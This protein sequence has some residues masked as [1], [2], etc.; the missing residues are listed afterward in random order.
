VAHKSA[1][2]GW[3]GLAIY[4][5]AYDAWA[6]KYGHE[7]L[8]R[9]CWRGLKHP[10]ARWPIMYATAVVVKHL[11]LPEFIPE[12]DPLRLVALKFSKGGDNEWQKALN[13]LI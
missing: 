3:L 13:G 10:V 12:V 6:I 9:A 2:F 5:T 8:S 4:V 1:T 11:M 7:T